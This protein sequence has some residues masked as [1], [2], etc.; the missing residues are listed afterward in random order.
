MIDEVYRACIAW[1]GR[2]RMRQ[3]AGLRLDSRLHAQIRGRIRKALESPDGET[4]LCRLLQGDPHGRA[5]W[6]VALGS[7]MVKLVYDWRERLVVT[8]TESRPRR[9]RGR[10]TH[11]T[12]DEL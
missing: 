9:R 6:N 1:H 8:V 12:A 5:K 3:R 2:R 7:R 11:G 10:R 4:N